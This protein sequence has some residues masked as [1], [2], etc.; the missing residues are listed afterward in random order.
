MTSKKNLKLIA[1]Q[2]TKINLLEAVVCSQENIIDD[3]TRSRSYFIDRDEK[4]L[5]EL[6]TSIQHRG[7]LSA[8]VAELTIALE[9]SDRLVQD[10]ITQFKEVDRLKTII[11]AINETADNSKLVKLLCALVDDGLTY[12]LARNINL[13]ENKTPETETQSVDMATAHTSIHWITDSSPLTNGI[14]IFETIRKRLSG[15][16]GKLREHLC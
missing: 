4:L 5:D 8:E 1:E 12:D 3:Q 9:H 10:L 15:Y 6:R 13:I 14:N 7:K 11:K 2:R 16:T